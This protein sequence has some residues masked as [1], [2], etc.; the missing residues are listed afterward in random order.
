MLLAPVVWVLTAVIAYFF[1]AKTWWFPPPIY[2]HGIAY[3]AQFMRTLVVTGIIFFL[4][5]F[6]LGY[7][8]VSS[9]TTAGRASYSHGNNKLETIWTSATAL[10]FI[11][12]VLMG[13]KIWAGVHFDEA[14]G[15]RHPD[16]SDGQTVRLEFPLSRTR[17][18]VRPHRSQTGQRFRR[19]S[20]RP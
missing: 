1:A 19:Q 2:A 12:L 4:A 13:T 9:A 18:Q 3:D 10:L 16:R 17:R 6:A 14:A 8:I 5:Q 15:R 7:V 11:G 20:V